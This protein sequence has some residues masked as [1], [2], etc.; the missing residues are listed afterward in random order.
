MPGRLLVCIGHL[1]SD[2]SAKL[3]RLTGYV[4]EACW[5]VCIVECRS[6]GPSRQIALLHIQS[7]HMQAGLELR[8]SLVRKG[9]PGPCTQN[10]WRWGHSC[11]LIPQTDISNSVT[12]GSEAQWRPVTVM[13]I[14]CFE[15]YRSDSRYFMHSKIERF[16]WPSILIELLAW[17][18]CIFRKNTNGCADTLSMIIIEHTNSSTINK[19]NAFR[20]T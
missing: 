2:S 14:N 18:S 3:S 15:W 17:N 7:W 19:M 6:L 5:G 12:Y 9:K 13:L 8:H 16:C 10:V 1:H 11:H 20:K 4:H